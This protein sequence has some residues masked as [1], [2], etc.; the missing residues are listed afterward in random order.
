MREGMRPSYG[1][2]HTPTPYATSRHTPTSAGVK[3]CSACHPDRDGHE[4]RYRVLR[5]R[6]AS[7]VE[8]LIRPPHYRGRGLYSSATGASMASHSQ[9]SP[10]MPPSQTERSRTARM[11]YVPFRQGGA[12]QWPTMYTSALC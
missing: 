5:K 6:E 7:V 9:Y 10:G 12:S 1:A 3:A 4:C 2:L 8:E 11:I